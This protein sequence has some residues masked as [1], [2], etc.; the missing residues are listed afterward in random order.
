MPLEIE[1]KMKVDDLDEIIRRLT[2]AGA[3]STTEH[4]ETNTFLDVSNRALQA[5]DKGLRMRANFD[6]KT[7]KSK[8]IV[9][10]KGPRKPGVLK[11]REEIE[12]GVDDAGAA[13]A[14]F[15]ELGFAP[16][17]SF[18]KR[19]RSWTLLSCKVELDE[20]PHIGSYVEVEGPSERQVNK[21]REAL[22]LADQPVISESYAALLANYLDRH[23]IA[24]RVIVLAPKGTI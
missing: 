12:F 17:L 4:L 15:A 9:T 10:F 19:R 23:K 1:A 22:G 2:S 18:Q 20:L 24:S 13:T 5:A 16:T 3:Q 11:S 21:A 14:M 8:S 7:G 6:V